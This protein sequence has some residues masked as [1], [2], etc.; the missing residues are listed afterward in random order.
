MKFDKFINEFEDE[1]EDEEGF[2]NDPDWAE[3]HSSKY[4]HNRGLVL[5][6]VNK[7]I[8]TKVSKKFISLLKKNG[9]FFTREVLRD[10]GAIKEFKTRL[11]RRPVDLNI[12]LHHFFD[13]ELEKKFGWKPRSQGVFV[14]NDINELNELFFPIGDFKY[15]YSPE[16]HDLYFTTNK[17]KIQYSIPD[18]KDPIGISDKS[19]KDLKKLIDTYKD[20]GIENEKEKL[21]VMFKCDS[22]ILVD[23]LLDIELDEI[24]DLFNL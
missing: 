19:T 16:V 10:F 5:K 1:E 6:E 18:K 3:R 4:H 13:K 21:E 15:V 11:D 17:M 22:Y 2:K 20:S 8:K 14:W 12:D 9:D 24:L 7:I 23:Y